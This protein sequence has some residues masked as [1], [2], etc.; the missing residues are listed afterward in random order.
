MKGLDECHHDLDSVR[1]GAIKQLCLLSVVD[2]YSVEVHGF[3]VCQHKCLDA[4]RV[5]LSFQVL[6]KRHPPLVGDDRLINGYLL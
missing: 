2:M 4:P 5:G 1:E 3:A 6:L